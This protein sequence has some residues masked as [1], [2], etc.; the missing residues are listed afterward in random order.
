[1]K[2]GSDIAPS[3]GPRGCTTDAR[4]FAIAYT[5]KNEA[6]LLPDAI[7]YHLQLGCSRIFVFFDGTTDNSPELVRGMSGVVCAESV[8][9][10]SLID[11]PEWMKL[12]LP[13]WEESM[14]VRKRINTFMA[15]EQARSE[16][17]EWLISIDPDELLL[18]GDVQASSPDDSAKFFSSVAAEIDQILVPNWE[19]VPVDAGT[20]RPFV[21]CTLF[22]RRFPITEAV[23]RYSSGLVRRVASN[24]KLHA[25]YDHWF[26]R[27]RFRGGIC[28]ALS[29]SNR[30]S[31]SAESNSPGFPAMDRP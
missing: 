22:L 12:L 25:W 24:P 27:I 17:I 7:A 1:M 14:D 6:N 21:D 16:G 10:K 15:A 9:P 26:Y 4:R 31:A 5:V 30:R 11:P 23:W 13:R 3:G 8:A 29:G 28:R 19:A 18:L 20:G 2:P